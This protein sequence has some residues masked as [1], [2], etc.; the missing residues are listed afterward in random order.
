MPLYEYHCPPCDLVFEELCSLGEAQTK[1]PCPDCGTKA[2]R[3]VSSFA[4][5]HGASGEPYDPV[6]AS[7]KN[8]RDPRPLCMQHSQIPLSCHMDEYS[9]KRF[10]AHAA[11]KGNAFDDSVAQAKEVRTQRGLKQPSYAPATHG[12]DHD[13]GHTHSSDTNFR[14]HGQAQVNQAQV[15]EQPHDHP[16][17][18][19]K[20][21]KRGKQP[22]HVH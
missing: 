12:H 20:G 22:A 9:V 16:H 10:A 18:R 11:G 5:S 8:A 15:Q 17:G 1:K 7:R 19:G 2:P 13:H 3:I 14:L 21:K 6:T 4:I